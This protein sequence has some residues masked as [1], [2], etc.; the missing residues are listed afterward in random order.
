MLPVVVWNELE[1]LI[2]RRGLLIV[3]VTAAV[4]GF[5]LVIDLATPQQADWKSQTRQQIAQLEADKVQA[6]RA[7]AGLPAGLEASLGSAIDQQIA[8]EQYL[9]DHDVPP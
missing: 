1:K 8:S 5:G 4:I 9:V 3:L 2:R 7:P 6:Q